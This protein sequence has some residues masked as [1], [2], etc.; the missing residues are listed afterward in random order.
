MAV[1]TPPRF[2]LKNVL[3]RAVLEHQHVNSEVKIPD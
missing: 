1:G 2:S 3:D